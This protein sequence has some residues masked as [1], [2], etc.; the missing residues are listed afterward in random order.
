MIKKFNAWME[1]VGAD[2]L[3]HFLVTAWLVAE[4]KLFGWVTMMAML[5]AIVMF[6]CLKEVLLDDQADWED[7]VWSICG[8]LLS[9]L[10]FLAYEILC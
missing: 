2:K 10:L 6:G 5:L 9:M 8:G 7:L 4:A 3:L 1:E